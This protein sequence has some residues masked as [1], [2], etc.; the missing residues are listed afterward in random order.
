LRHGAREHDVVEQAQLGAELLAAGEVRLGVDRRADDDQPA[1]GIEP[2]VEVVGLDEVFHPLV[3]GESPDEEEVGPAGVQLL[4][5]PDRR[6]GVLLPVEQDRQ[7]AGPGEAG[8][9]EL[10]PVELGHAERQVG[11][12]PEPG[13]LEAPPAAEV[14]D[15]RADADEVLRR[16]DVVVDD[17]AP[18]RQTREEAGHLR[19]DGEVEERDRVGRGHLSVAG[20]EVRVPQEAHVPVLR[21]HVGGVPPA[22]EETPQRSNVV[23]DGVARVEVRH[24]LVDGAD[25]VRSHPSC[26]PSRRKT[27]R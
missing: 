26:A 27:S 4:E 6:V 9:L 8:G 22:P 14:G 13:E 3:R 7:D 10:P 16:S 12:V 11:H 5:R 2:P 23:A 21:V 18:V 20:V 24:E 15:A 25:A 17:G 1:V 19:A